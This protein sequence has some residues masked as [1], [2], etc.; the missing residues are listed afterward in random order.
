MI[1]FFRYFT[2]PHPLCHY[3]HDT[4]LILKIYTIYECRFFFQSLQSFMEFKY[5][6]NATRTLYRERSI[7]LLLWEPNFSE[8]PYE[9]ITY[10][11]FWLV[12]NIRT[13]YYILHPGGQWKY[14]N[15]TLLF[16]IFS[17]PKMRLTVNS[18][19][20]SACIVYII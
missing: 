13:V 9:F 17:R 5:I 15:T 18:T 16:F 8:K 6:K 3:G 20:A 7:P 4:D 10:T 19:T 11:T 12:W 14:M 2:E 1:F